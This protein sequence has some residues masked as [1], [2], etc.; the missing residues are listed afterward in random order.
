MLKSKFLESECLTDQNDM[1]IDSQLTNFVAGMGRIKLP[2]PFG[3]QILSPQK[4]IDTENDWVLL[5]GILI[6]SVNELV[7]D[8]PSKKQKNPLGPVNGGW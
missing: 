3:Q 6:R 2:W 1:R 4:P 5:Y 7:P 8:P